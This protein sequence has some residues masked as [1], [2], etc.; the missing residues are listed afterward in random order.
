[1]FTEQPFLPIDSQ[2]VF[3]NRIWDSDDVADVR[4]GALPP[5]EANYVQ[6]A[7]WALPPVVF[8]GHMCSPELFPV[9]EA[10]PI[11][12][13]LPPVTILA[14]WIPECCV[15]AFDFQAG[16]R[17][18]VNSEPASQ[19]TQYA[20][21][22]VDATATTPFLQF[23]VG[24]AINGVSPS[25][26]GYTLSYNPQGTSGPTGYRETVVAGPTGIMQSVFREFNIDDENFCTH[27]MS[28]FGQF[29]TVAV[30]GTQCFLQIEM[31]AGVGKLCGLN[32]KICPDILPTGVIPYTQATLTATGTDEAG[33]AQIITPSVVIDAA[34]VDGAG[35]R[36]PLDIDGPTEVNVINPSAVD[37]YIVYA[38]SGQQIVTTVTKVGLISLAPEQCCYLVR[39]SDT[40][41]RLV[42][43][44]DAT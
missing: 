14:G 44:G 29:W 25:L 26:R 30:G 37:S 20:I 27:T 11:P 19:L 17:V 39:V 10:W 3:M 28:A 22:A 41:W 23:V 34:S 18:P 43:Q 33:A 32:L 2:C 5:G 16:S 8:N 24:N 40:N 15:M 9:G 21:P 7:R 42:F 1:M 35:V 13:T 31:V 12:S 4:V 38:A 6:D 36:L